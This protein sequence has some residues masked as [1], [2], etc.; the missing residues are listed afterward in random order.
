MS[1]LYLPY[2]NRVDLIGKKQL[3]SYHTIQ[4]GESFNSHIY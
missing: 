3:I 4:K 2:G 1:A